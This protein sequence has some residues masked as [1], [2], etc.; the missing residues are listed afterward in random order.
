[1]SPMHGLLD[2]DVTKADD[3]LARSGVLAMA[4][5]DASV[6]LTL[7][8][9]PARYHLDIDHDGTHTNRRQRQCVR[10]VD[11]RRTAVNRQGDVCSTG[12]T[13][14]T[15]RSGHRVRQ[16]RRERRFDGMVNGPR[17]RDLRP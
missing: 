1:M 9:Y 6:D 17:T 13:R 15:A 4:L 8:S 2:L 10:P 3:L 5:P 16:S 12:R 7:L 11:R 14:S